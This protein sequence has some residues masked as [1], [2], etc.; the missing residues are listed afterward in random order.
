MTGYDC[1]IKAVLFQLLSKKEFEIHFRRWKSLWC[2]FFSSDWLTSL[3][4]IPSTTLN[5]RILAKDALNCWQKVV[6]E[7]GKINKTDNFSDEPRD[8]IHSCS[9]RLYQTQSDK[10]RYNHTHQDTTRHY[11][12]LPYT[13][14]HNQ[15][16]SDTPYINKQYQ[17][18]SKA[19]RCNLIQPYTS[20][21]I[22][23]QPDYTRQ[24]QTLSADQTQTR[25]QIIDISLQCFFGLH[26]Q[27]QSQT[28]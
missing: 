5:M 16:L 26:N 21:H 7:K 10:T 20:S 3:L 19:T 17:T 2:F 27:S 24:N 11:Q 1:F 8:T 9:T 28:E 25:S 23:K 6:Q 15:T 22:Q 12:T 18:Q 4:V 13:S 14:R